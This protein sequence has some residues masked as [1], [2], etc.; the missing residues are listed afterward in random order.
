MNRIILYSIY[1]LIIGLLF[2]CEK[3]LEVEGKAPVAISF[4]KPGIN[5]I[6]SYDVGE[7]Y[8]ADI[9]VAK[10]G[11]TSIESNVS[12]EINK[13]ILDSLNLTD[14]SSYELLPEDCYTLD[15]TSISFSSKS[16]LEKGMISYNPKKIVE[17]SSFDLAKYALPVQL[18]ATNPK[19]LTPNRDKMILIFTVSEPTLRILNPGFQKIDLADDNIKSLDVNI[20]VEF[21]NK[22]D[23]DIEL[24]NNIELVNKYNTENN[25]FYAIMPSSMFKAPEKIKLIKG[26]NS[27]ISKYI[28]NKEK[29]L[30]GNYLLPIQIGNISSS[31]DGAS[32]NVIK[33]NEKT[34]VLYAFS[35]KGEKI[36]KKAWSITSF[37][38]EEPTG[39]G[40]NNGH[41]IHLI[42]DDSGTFWHSKWKGGQ[43][44]LPY[45]ITIDMG[46]KHLVSQIEIL[47][48]GGGSNNPI[49]VLSFE[50]S[51]DNENWTFI[52]KFPF[53][54]TNSSLMY[55]V[56]ATEARF[57][58]M[59]LPEG[60]NTS[61]IAAIRELTA[62]GKSL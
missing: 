3:N 35:K 39:E 10:G 40:A 41:A 29:L 49:K 7:I 14:G 46:E 27:I 2:S 38:T 50:T 9:W 56:K 60:E 52:G 31:L 55:A 62:Y 11:L 23:I 28:I 4:S 51:M 21:T 19:E 45:Q 32:T 33:F 58:R 17:K 1:L 25:S 34:S 42:D 18:K 16:N 6:L 47:P 53:K 36:P 43:T 57:I 59:S 12:L 24:V 61:R 30:P 20:G 54:N 13:S 22:W 8:K 5:K 48:R 44:P 26:E 37:T 15:V